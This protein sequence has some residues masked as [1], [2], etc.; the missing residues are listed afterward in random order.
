LYAPKAETV[1]A[2]E[3]SIAGGAPEGWRTSY[4]LVLLIVG[5][6][7]M[8]SFIGWEGW[9]KYP[10]MPLRIWRDK[11]FSLVGTHLLLPS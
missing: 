8:G 1:E 3:N 4:V 10:L 7:L 5:V 11:N 9:C 2:D 6:F